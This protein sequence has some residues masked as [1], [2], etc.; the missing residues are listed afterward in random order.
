M[1]TVFDDNLC[2][3]YLDELEKCGVEIRSLVVRQGGRVTFERCLKP[4]SSDAVHPLYSVTKSFT[5]IAIGYLVSDGNIDVDTPWIKWFPEYENGVADKRMLRVTVRDL[6]TMQMG[7][8]SDIS[9]LDKDDDWALEVLAR[10]MDWEPGTH[11]HYDSLCSH[12]LS[13]LVERVSGKK[14]SDFLDERLFRPLGITR[15]WWEEDSRSHSTGGFGL[16][17]STKDLSKFGQCL[18]DGGAWDGKQVIPRGWISEATRRQV[19]THPFYPEDATEDNNGYGYQFWMSRGG[20]YRCSGLFGQ[21]C[22]IRPEDDA[23]IAISASTTGSK[24]LLDP[25]Y[26]VIDSK[27]EAPF[28]IIDSLPVLAGGAHGG[29]TSESRILGTHTFADNI[30]GLE[31]VR[32]SQN[33]SSLSLSLKKDGAV[34]GAKA[35]CGNWKES[36]IDE[37]AVGEMFQFTTHRGEHDDAPLWDKRTQFACYGWESPTVLVFET[38]EL[39]FT[40]RCN[41]RLAVSGNYVTVSIAASSMA[42]AP[43]PNAMM[44]VSHL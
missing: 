40:R 9:F 21:L 23:V 32:L 30:Y 11:F 17:L 24:A 38:R 13:L 18:L 2:N 15:W 43:Q 41:I 35:S 33:E 5:S 10:E 14:E 31:E 19:D 28:A 39:D 3:R 16:H 6:L 12:L 8:N 27:D 42:C 4:F 25:L 26:R 29:P 44:A 37:R 1:R 34:Y 36:P 20:G 7:Q 22:Y